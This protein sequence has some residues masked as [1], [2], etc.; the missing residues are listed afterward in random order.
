[1]LQESYYN[2]W[3]KRENQFFLLNTLS[4]AVCEID[5]ESYP[6]IIAY[7][8]NPNDESRLDQEKISIRK[9]NGF[10]IDS[11]INETLTLEYWYNAT[12]FRTDILK[13]ILLPTMKCNCKCEYCFQYND[14]NDTMTKQGLESIKEYLKRALS[15][16]KY[17]SL[18]LF[19]GEPLLEWDLIM[20][21][22]NY[23]N[24]LEKT[25]NFK[26]NLS[27]VT[28]GY[29]LTKDRALCLIQKY[30]LESVQ[31]TIDGLSREKHDSMRKL[32]NG[33]GTYD[34]IMNNIEDTIQI[35]SSGYSGTSVK[36]RLNLFNNKIYELKNFLSHF[37]KKDK[38]YLELIIRGIYNT[39]VFKK[40]NSNLLEI[41]RFVLEAKKQGF[42]V[43][44]SQGK[45]GRFYYCEGDGGL[46]T[47]HLYPDLS[48]WKCG[49]DRSINTDNIGNLNRGGQVTLD[50]NK[51]INYHKNN[52]FKDGKCRECKYLPICF[53]GCPIS[54]H[55]TGKRF[56]YIKNRS[57]IDIL[58]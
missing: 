23:I 37:T 9:E 51:V 31:F 36:I 10:V 55:M 8:N 38:D 34:Q 44:E 33:A 17:F 19:G 11:N 52:P 56:C 32:Q 24:Q 54:F 12:Y 15:E 26:F 21:L 27:L 46:N 7:L 49:M 50:M 42:V 13:I 2:L 29:L 53:G 1:M 35:V 6:F 18:A 41:D 43:F 48:I 39:N 22:L 28:N 40:K 20:E 14:K 25:Y 57:I 4:K 5:E 30:Y 45:L 3:E 16:I 47:F 58:T